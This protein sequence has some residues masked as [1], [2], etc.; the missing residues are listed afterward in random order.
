MVEALAGFGVGGGRKEIPE[1][2]I[3]QTTELFFGKPTSTN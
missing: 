2:G 1:L 3:T